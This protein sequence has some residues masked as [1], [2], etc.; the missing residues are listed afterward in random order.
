MR[1]VSSDLRPCNYVRDQ[2]FY[3]ITPNDYISANQANTTNYSC[4]N[5]LFGPCA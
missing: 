3:E 4:W 2:D 5:A 1:Y